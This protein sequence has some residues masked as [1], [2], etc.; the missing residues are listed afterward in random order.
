MDSVLKK[1]ILHILL[2]VI[3][4]AKS[5]AKTTI[6]LEGGLNLSHYSWKQG[7]EYDLFK[8]KHAFSAGTRIG[9]NFSI[10]LLQSLAFEPGFFYVHQGFTWSATDQYRQA[11]SSW[12][13]QFSGGTTYNVPPFDD[14]VNVHTLEVPLYLS[15]RTFAKRNH[16]F[17]VGAGPYFGYN[18]FGTDKNG[19]SDTKAEP[20]DIGKPGGFSRTYTGAGVKLGYFLAK[21]F[22]VKSY[23]QYNLTN[24]LSSQG[25]TNNS[26]LKHY[27][28]GL[29]VG[30]L[31]SK[32]HH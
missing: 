13:Q 5:H 12:G 32:K 11:L 23:Y 8:Q 27:N 4:N 9:V 17:S 18:M 6:S 20:L 19:I 7:S 15:L 2:L 14:K 10:P 26:K 25:G 31:L 24:E 30:Y 28:F 1:I 16:Y 22:S 21:G 3:W 29:T